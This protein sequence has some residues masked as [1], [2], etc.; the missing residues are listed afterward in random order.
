[1]TYIPILVKMDQFVR[2]LVTENEHTR[3]TGEP[4]V[5]SEPLDLYSGGEGFECRLDYH[6]SWFTRRHKPEDFDVNL[7]LSEN[8]ESRVL[9]GIFRGFFSISK[10]IQLLLWNE[11]RPVFFEILSIH[12]HLSVSF[13]HNLCS[14][15]D[16]VK[17]PS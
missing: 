9:I 13:L 6:L 17:W 7:R 5:L 8:L 15:N 10:R 2:N 11:P 3:I 4:G 16:V 12:D 14:L 1:V